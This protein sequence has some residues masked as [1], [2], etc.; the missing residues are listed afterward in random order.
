MSFRNKMGTALHNLLESQGAD[1]A[2]RVVKDL[3]E[4]KKI[5]P[6]DFSIKEVWEQCTLHEFGKIIPATE[7]IA[8][9]SFPK[10]TG[11]LINS[12]IISAYDAI[13][14][15]GD[16]LA[17]TVQ[18]NV[19]RETVAG[20]TGAEIPDEVPELHEYKDSTL[21]EKTVTGR[22]I[23]YG[24]LLSISEEAITFDKTGQIMQRAQGIGEAAAQWREK[25]IIEGIQDVNT[26]VYNPSGIPT[27]FYSSGNANLATSN[28]FG[29]AGMEAVLKLVH[30]QKSDALGNDADNYIGV[31]LMDPVMLAPQDLE[32]EA[33]QL[34]GST[35]VPESNDNAVNTFK[36]KFRVVISPYVSQQSSTTWYYGDFKKDFWWTEVW[37]LQTFAQPA[38]HQDA[39]LADIKARFKTRFFGGIMAIS[40]QHSYK[41]TA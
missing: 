3:L 4:S 33:L 17:T 40:T 25:I 9:S 23:K 6:G 28:A 15:V 24:R 34:I 37:P 13:A 27:A 26:N 5:A 1:G 30:F 14:K 11:E 8:S 31:T 36:G 20:I 2:T 7:A 32:V 38:N 19:E 16:Q 41:S 22:S 18:S 21:T 10:I 35:S 29:E 12:R 39:F